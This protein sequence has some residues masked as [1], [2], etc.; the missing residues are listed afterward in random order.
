VEKKIAGE[1]IEVA[2]EAAPA[3][4]VDLMD[5]LKASVEAAKKKTPAARPKAKSGAKKTAAKKTAAPRK[6]AATG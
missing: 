5:A 6:K 1:E 2:P 4:V 3:R